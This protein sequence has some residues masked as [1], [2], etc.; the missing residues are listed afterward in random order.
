MM[1]KRDTWLAW[2]TLALIMLWLILSVTKETLRV[3][4]VIGVYV[5]PWFAIADL[6][7]APT[8]ITIAGSPIRMRAELRFM[9]NALFLCS[10]SYL[11]LSY[12]RHPLATVTVI[13]IICADAFWLMP[14]WHRWYRTRFSSTEQG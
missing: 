9:L 14:K 12:R 13:A 2:A 8:L 7:L 6:V 5:P 4:A 1:G 3:V 11:Y 10:F